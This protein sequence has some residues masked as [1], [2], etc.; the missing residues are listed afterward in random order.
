VYLRER[1][2]E[3]GS[4]RVT[5]LGDGRCDGGRSHQVLQCTDLLNSYGTRVQ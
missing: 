1:Q 4:S 5:G 3:W 2:R